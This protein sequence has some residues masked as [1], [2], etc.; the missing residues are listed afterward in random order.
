MA[1]RSLGFDLCSPKRAG[2][3]NLRLSVRNATGEL[4]RRFDATG[5][6][7]CDPAGIFG[8]QAEPDGGMELDAGVEPIPDLDPVSDY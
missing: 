3:H 5:F 1:P 4:T 8:P 2:G 6:S 7:P